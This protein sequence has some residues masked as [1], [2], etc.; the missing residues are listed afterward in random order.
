MKQLSDFCVDLMALS[1]PITD[2]ESNI[3]IRQ[4]KR[5]WNDVSI[6]DNDATVTTSCSLEVC[7]WEIKE[8]T[9]LVFDLKLICPVPTRR[10]R[11]VSAQNTV[12]P[13]VFP[14]LDS[15]PRKSR[16]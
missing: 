15:I 10:Y 16:K 1:E 13:R 14:M 6:V 11:T 3:S 5:N 4:K 9:N 12:L 2:K 7:R 8:T